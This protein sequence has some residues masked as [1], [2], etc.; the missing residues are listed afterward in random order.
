MADVNLVTFVVPLM[1]DLDVQQTSLWEQKSLDICEKCILFNKLDPFI[2]IVKCGLNIGLD[3]FYLLAG[4]V[5]LR[6]NSSQY[7]VEHSACTINML[8]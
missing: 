8:Q 5:C 3:R 2:S 4:H 6:H 7:S 1:L